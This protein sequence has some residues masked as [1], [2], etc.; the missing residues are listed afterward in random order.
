[1]T[2]WFGYL[3]EVEHFFATYK[4]FDGVTSNVEDWVSAKNAT[5]EAETSVDWHAQRIARQGSSHFFRRG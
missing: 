5:A 1:M 4:Y 2:H 3:C